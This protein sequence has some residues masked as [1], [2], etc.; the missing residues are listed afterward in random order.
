MHESCKWRSRLSSDGKRPSVHVT[1]RELALLLAGISYPASAGADPEISSFDLSLLDRRETPNELF[2][3]RNHFPKPPLSV[4]GWKVVLSKA[5]ETQVTEIT[6]N[7]LMQMPVVKVA[8]TLECAE[9]PPGGGLVSHAIWEGVRL[10]DVLERLGSS[11]SMPFIRLSGADG[12][13]RT[14]GIAPTELDRI[15]LAY[16]MNGSTLSPDHGGPLRAVVPGRYGM[17]SV[18]WLRKIELVSVNDHRNDYR[19]KIRSLLLGVSEAGEIGPQQVKSVFSR[20]TSG[21]ILFGRRFILRGAAWAGERV[22]SKVEVSSNG[23]RTWMPALLDSP[24]PFC[25]AL[26]QCEWKIPASGEYELMVR[27]T[28]AEG[29]TQPLERPVDRVDPFEQNTCQHLTVTVR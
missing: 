2:F 15:L 16:R 25:W 6:L 1:R 14:V 17:D 24:E 21:A 7:D 22:V 19:R 9:N 8:A 3:I 29:N 18:K 13:A 26:W 20:P 12:F 4:H 10:K 27:A 5:T 28:D 23:G 11:P